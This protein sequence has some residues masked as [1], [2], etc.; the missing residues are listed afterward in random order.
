MFV[1]EKPFG[2]RIGTHALS[3]AFNVIVTNLKLAEKRGKKPKELRLYTLRKAFSKFMAVKVD[4][5]CVEYWLGHTST[6]THYASEDIEH[7]RKLYGQGY[8]ELR[9]EAPQV[10]A[11]I[12]EELK[13]KDEEIK[14]LKQTMEKMQPLLKFI[15]D[16]KNQNDDLQLYVNTWL[17][18]QQKKLTQQEGFK[19]GEVSDKMSIELAK[20]LKEA[21][22]L[23][24]E[25]LFA[26][27]KPKP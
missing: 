12:T 4:R 10:P 2:Q 27:K 17:Q 11:S 24:L 16:L 6:A 8:S 1:T 9:L 19:V 21:L 5:A 25:E 26:K 15:E 14:E 20:T 13:K 18:T 3:Q 23:G 7:H 22:N